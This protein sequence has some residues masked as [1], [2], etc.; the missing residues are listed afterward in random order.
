M[1]G[2]ER[3]SEKGREKVK[4]GAR[5]RYLKRNRLTDGCENEQKERFKK[6]LSLKKFFWIS[7]K[8]LS[9]SLSSSNWT[10]PWRGSTD[11]FR[12]HQRG[13]KG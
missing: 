13:L 4:G 8:F 6:V 11:L 9:W 2:G 1:K 3:E 12:Y 10:P 5:I 7:R